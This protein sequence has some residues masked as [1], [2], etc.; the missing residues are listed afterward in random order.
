MYVYAYNGGAVDVA[1][2]AADGDFNN[3][4][5]IGGRIS[6]GANFCYVHLS[7]YNSTSNL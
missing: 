5:Q 7:I 3:R 6:A 4:V 1:R 2:C